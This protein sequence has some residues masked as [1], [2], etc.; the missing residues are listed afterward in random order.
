MVKEIE[1]DELESILNNNSIV[2]LDCYAVWCGPCRMLSPLI[3][4]LA[5]EVNNVCFAKANIDNNE[6]LALKYN[7]MSIPTLLLFK[8]GNL[9]DKVIGFKTKDELLEIIKKY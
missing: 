5:S 8:D 6:E 4:E 2:M 7:I 1:Y 3:D 9:V